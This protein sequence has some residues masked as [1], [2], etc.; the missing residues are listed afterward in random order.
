MNGTRAQQLEKDKKLEEALEALDDGDGEE[1]LT[2]DPATGELVPCPR[3]ESGDRIPATQM[4]REGFF[5]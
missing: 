1:E 2:F 4:A 5:R 3:G